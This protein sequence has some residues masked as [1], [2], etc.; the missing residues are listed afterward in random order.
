MS[1]T[2]RPEISVIIPTH[3]RPV[4][5]LGAIQSVAEQTV[6]P[7]EIIIV[8]DGSDITYKDTIDRLP[9]GTF[10]YNYI[11]CSSSG[12][13]GRARNIGAAAATGDI[14][15]FLDDDDRWRPQKVEGQLEVF[16]RRPEVDLVYSGRIAVDENGTELYRIDANERGDL[17][18]RILLRNYIGTTSSVAVSAG[19]FDRAGGFDPEMPA[20]QDW[21]LW[22][23]LCQETIV[24]VDKKYTVEW[25]AHADPG[26]QMTSEPK[27]YVRAIDRIETKHAA[28]LAT[29]DWI[30]RRQVT[31][32]RYSSIADKYARAGSA[33]R[34]KY[35][36]QSL[37]NYPTL[38]ALSR[39]LPGS[40]LMRLRTALP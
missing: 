38:T 39:V 8:N 33:K 35:I 22:I 37:A 11:E 18:E 36:A 15:M 7:T 5:L 29:L 32:Y 24:G 23:R 12:G 31:A 14:Y 6:T 2:G 1:D 16:D 40:V 28:K 30:T 9:T 27:R 21:E 10:E 19:V 3:N 34:F 4:R 25:T 13:A 20:L 26:E 17:A